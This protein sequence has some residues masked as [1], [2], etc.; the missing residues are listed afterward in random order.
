MVGKCVG[1]ASMYFMLGLAM[2]K[3]FM[4]LDFGTFLCFLHIHLQLYRNRGEKQ[5]AKEA[6]DYAR[7]I[8]PSLAIPWA[9]M[10]ADL[11][12]R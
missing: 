1:S 2:M 12:I 9:G 10:S 11:N 7:S 6:F 4:F 8:D 5:L 3:I